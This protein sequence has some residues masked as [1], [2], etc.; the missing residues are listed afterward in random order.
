[1]TSDTRIDMK[2]KKANSPF[3]GRWKIVEMEQWDRDYIDLE[4]PGFIRFAGDNLGGFQ[5][6]AAQGELDYRVVESASPPR[7]E[8]SWSGHCDSD[9]ASGRGWAEVRKDKLFGHLYF[10]LGDESWFRAEKAH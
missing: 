4:V 7:I 6:G 9:P 2:A 1:M 10:H 8:F 3:R 5:F